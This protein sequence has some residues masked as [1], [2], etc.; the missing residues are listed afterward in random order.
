MNKINKNLTVVAIVSGLVCFVSGMAYT[1][2]FIPHS[3]MDTLVIMMIF[4]ASMTVI[5]MFAA[6]YDY[7]FNTHAATTIVNRN[8]EQ[9][10][11]QSVV[12]APT[13]VQV[14]CYQIDISIEQTPTIIQ[15]TDEKRTIIVI[16]P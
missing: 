10:M 13:A 16:N 4:S 1:F 2:R 3:S 7:Y 11:Q 9:Q 12:I 15:D 6:I 8:T 14:P 5:T